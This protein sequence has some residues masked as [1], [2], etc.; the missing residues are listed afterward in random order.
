MRCYIFINILFLIVG[1][2]QL[3]NLVYPGGKE[4][5]KRSLG[6]QCN[7]LEDQET[8]RN[9]IY[10]R[11]YVALQKALTDCD[12]S[13]QFYLHN[14][15]TRANDHS[16]SAV[17]MAKFFIN[18]GAQPLEEDLPALLESDKSRGIK[19][20]LLS[21]HGPLQTVLSRGNELLV[22]FYLETMSPENIAK[23]SLSFRAIN[24]TDLVAYEERYPNS[25]R[26]I[27]SHVI[28]A[29]SIYQGLNLAIEKNAILC[30]SNKGDNCKALEHL[31]TEL[32]YMHQ[33]IAEIAKYKG[34]MSKIKLDDHN[35]LMNKQLDL[36]IK[37]GMTSPKTYDRHAQVVQSSRR[38]L[39][40]YKKAYANETGSNLNLNDC[41]DY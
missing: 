7:T 18:E 22:K 1:C 12:L 24:L 28:K 25:D 41:K 31:Q 39:N 21:V 34:C 29:P 40:V 19:V 26:Y 2:S 13:D 37:T 11:S 32:G 36:G 20:S 8:I 10:T 16:P 6:S 33:G 4:V 17:E 9:A 15:L 23:G 30:G 35:E 14:F 5:A 38:Y 3:G 27:V